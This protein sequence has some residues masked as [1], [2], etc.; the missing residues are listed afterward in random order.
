MKGACGGG[1]VEFGQM[2]AV[3]CRTDPRAFPSHGRGPR[4]DPLCVHQKRPDLLGF[5]SHPEKF[6]GSSIRNEARNAQ[7]DPW[8]FRGL[9]SPCSPCSANIKEI[10]IS[11]CVYMTQK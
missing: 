10:K 2:C 8:T 4:F 1:G 5:S 9:C 3:R 6:I 11:A 7:L